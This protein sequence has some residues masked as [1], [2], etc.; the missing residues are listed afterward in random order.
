ML[1]FFVGAVAVAALLGCST[2]ASH[3]DS[4]EALVLERAQARWNALLAGDWA[5]AY[6]YMTPAYREIVPLSRYGNQFGGPAKWQAAA[7]KDAKCE[8]RRC[9]VG[10]E[11]QFRLFLPGHSDRPMSTYVEEIWILEEGQWYKFD[12]PTADLPRG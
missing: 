10:M 1:R 3:S 12:P 2:T 7:A 6:R 9:V 8:E 4:P 5:A 11:V